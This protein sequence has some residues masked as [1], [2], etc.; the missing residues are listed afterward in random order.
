[1]SKTDDPGIVPQKPSKGI[2]E[3]RIERPVADKPTLSEIEETVPIA[4][5]DDKR[6]APPPPTLV[7]DGIPLKDPDVTQEEIAV[8]DAVEKPENTVKETEAFTWA[9]LEDEFE[10]DTLNIIPPEE[11]QY[12]IGTI[13]AEN[14]DPMNGVNVSALGTQLTTMTNIRGQFK[15]EWQ[16]DIEKLEFY[17]NGYEKTLANVQGPGTLSVKMTQLADLELSD[18]TLTSEPVPAAAKAKKTFIGK[19]RVQPVGGYD[20][21]KKYIKQNKVLPDGVSKG[22]VLIQFVVQLDGSL[23]S[24]KILQSTSKALEAEAIR[25]LTQGLQWENPTSGPEVVEY[26]VKF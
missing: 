2:A 9:D 20:A 18:V 7:I 15:M 3:T 4:L 25:L 14:D 10:K 22:E 12:I 6:N 17:Y 13:L 1:M 11:R 21:L 16:P 5:A 8:A 24:V 26:V 23:T 19:S